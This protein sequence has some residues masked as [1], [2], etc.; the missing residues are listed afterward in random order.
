MLKYMENMILQEINN[1]FMETDLQ[2]QKK[3]ID[4]IKSD[5]NMILNKFS[6]PEENKS[7]LHLNI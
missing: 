1:Y 4:E 7:Q 3:S 5:I 2:T 6:E